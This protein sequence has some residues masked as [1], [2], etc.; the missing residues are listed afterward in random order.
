MKKFP[1]KIASS[2]PSS[3]NTFLKKLFIFNFMQ[4]ELHFVPKYAEL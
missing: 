1:L 2:F 4:N 3:G